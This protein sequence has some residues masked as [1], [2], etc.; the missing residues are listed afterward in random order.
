MD[1]TPELEN[2]I[3]EKIS[4]L[5]KFVQVLKREEEKRTSAE[6]FVDIEKETLHHKKGKVFKAEAKILLPGRKIMAM[7]RGDDLLGVIVKIKDELQQEIKKYKEK[8]TD[9]T[10]RLRRGY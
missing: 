10:R 5:K 9:L 1:L 6:V 4:S 3:E 2:F 8:K 7:A